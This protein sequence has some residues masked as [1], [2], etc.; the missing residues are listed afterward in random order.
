[1]TP[2]ICLSYM[3][4]VMSVLP[5]AKVTLPQ[6]KVFCSDMDEKKLVGA[7]PRYEST[8]SFFMGHYMNA[9]QRLSVVWSLH[10]WS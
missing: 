4:I 10:S 7:S 6:K 2:I 9:Y 3:V 5:H 8:C 1:M